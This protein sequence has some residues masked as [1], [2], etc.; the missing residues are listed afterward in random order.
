MS[1]TVAF[2][3][4]TH[5]HHRGRDQHLHFTELEAAHHV[6]LFVAGQAPV[7]QTHT[8]LGEDAAR[9]LL[10]HAHGGPQIELSPSSITG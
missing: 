2:G 3:T 4:S 8:Q 6:F 7:R 10:E 1:I 5:F 9:K